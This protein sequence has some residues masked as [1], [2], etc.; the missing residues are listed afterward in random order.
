MKPKFVIA[1]G[2]REPEMP[3]FQSSNTGRIT[4]RKVA[5]FGMPDTSFVMAMVGPPGSGKTSLMMGLMHTIYKHVFRRVYFVSPSQTHLPR[6]DFDGIPKSRRFT[7]L[8]AEVLQ[9]IRKDITENRAGPNLII[10]DDVGS[11]L[12]NTKRDA[13]AELHD[14]LNN[15]RH[16]GENGGTSVMFL[17]QTWRQMELRLRNVIDSLVLVGNTIASK[18]RKAIFEEI[19]DG[20]MNEEEAEEIFK[21]YMQPHKFLHIRRGAGERDFLWFNFRRLL[22][23]GR[24]TKE[25]DDNDDS[26]ESDSEESS[27]DESDDETP[28]AKRRSR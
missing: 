23:D 2:P 14:L 6:S 21:K 20:L 15:H 17:L 28:P 18:D 16:I 3:V 5:K 8:S 1:K 12:K 9:Q 26:E 27:S 22:R 7:T 24:K 13:R 25:N 4:K 10:F 19:L 11:L